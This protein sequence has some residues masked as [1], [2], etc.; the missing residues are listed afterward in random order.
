VIG[1]ER[2]R[3]RDC[4][5][6]TVF[7]VLHPLSRPSP[8]KLIASSRIIFMRRFF[9]HPEKQHKTPASTA[10]GDMGRP[11]RPSATADG[12]AV[13]FSVVEAASPEGVIVSGV[14]LHD[15][16]EGK[17]AAQLND[18]AE[19]NPFSGV[20]VMV[21]VTLF[22]EVTANVDGVAKTEKSGCGRLMV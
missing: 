5:G 3:D 20:T 22:P 12:D 19:L 13:N 15:T 11:S 17:P 9:L 7:I 2:E 6:D 4:V 14:K 8:I 18:T 1:D 16:L 10:Q 21:V